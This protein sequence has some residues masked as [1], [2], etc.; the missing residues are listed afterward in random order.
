MPSPR[1]SHACV[2]RGIIAKDRGDLTPVRPNLFRPAYF[3]RS[4]FARFT[5]ARRFSLMRRC[6]SF[7][8]KLSNSSRRSLAS[9]RSGVT[10]PPTQLGYASETVGA[11]LPV[12]MPKP[13]IFVPGDM[14]RWMEGD[15]W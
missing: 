4:S 14:G 11:S 1:C 15:A 5:S 12:K 10:S 6:I 2:L 9:D 13:L 7:S 3:A 8:D